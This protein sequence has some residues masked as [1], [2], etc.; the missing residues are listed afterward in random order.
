VGEKKTLQFLYFLRI[1]TTIKKEVN[2]FQI[3]AARIFK[4]IFETFG[5]LFAFLSFQN[6]TNFLNL[7]IITNQRTI[8]IIEV[9][10]TTV[11]A[12]A[13]Q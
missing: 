7:L 1:F 11:H 9:Y 8:N 12:R 5:S 6:V 13:A 2:I 3:S 10:I 4:R